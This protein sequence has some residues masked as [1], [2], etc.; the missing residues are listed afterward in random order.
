MDKKFVLAMLA[1]FIIAGSI[2]GKRVYIQ[3]ASSG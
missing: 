1:L 3:Q 2:V